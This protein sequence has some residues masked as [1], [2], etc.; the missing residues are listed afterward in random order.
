MATRTMLCVL[1]KTALMLL[2]AA[3]TAWAQSTTQPPTQESSSSASSTPENM[4]T[5][6]TPVLSP[7]ETDAPIRQVGT[8]F[9][10]RMDP[11]GYKIGPLHA[12]NVSTSGFYDIATP[13]TGNSQQLWG[14]SVATNLVY[15]HNVTNG[16]LAI[17][18]NPV[19]S[20]TNGSTYLNSDASI[21]FSKQLTARWS[22][23]AAAQ[24]TYFQNSYL[25]QTPQ[26]LLAYA[27]GGIVLQTLYAQHSGSTMYESNSFS[28]NYQVSGRTQLALSPIVNFSFTDVAGSS[29]L[30]G[31][32]GG[33]ATLTH[34][35]TPNRSAF[36]YTSLSRAYSSLPSNAV[37][38]VDTSSTGGWNAFSV[39]GGFN[40]KLGQSWFVAATLG[41]SHQSGVDAGWT[42]TGTVSIMKTL[43]N[44]TLSG[45]YSRT[46]AAQ[47]LLTKGYFDQADI[48]YSR[49]LGQKVGA[50]IGI[51]EFR[52]VGTGG[53]NHGRRAYATVSY[54]WL[55]N[56]A[57]SFSYN[58]SKQ[59]ATQ[60]TLYLGTTNYMS[61]GL[62]WVL[63]Q[64]SGR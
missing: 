22:M 64:P 27:G 51:G 37:T 50:S 11:G 26:Y 29:Y 17:Q 34:S 13:P 44:G 24:W 41:A 39:G 1:G 2:L 59:T 19:L 6:E 54:R 63:G 42:P 35:F 20:I 32:L 18:A 61:V 40:Q 62:Q 49:H 60:S 46:M 8:P 9:P 38:S 21:D 5:A 58:Y 16:V 28:M 23:S 47:V 30:Q 43:K 25:L 48:A 7:A 31:N 56:L 10:L 3:S 4:A 57:W 33:G 45:A 36:V 55:H 15:M 52:S 12:L 53:N 14:T